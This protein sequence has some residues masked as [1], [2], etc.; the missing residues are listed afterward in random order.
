MPR[1]GAP[2]LSVAIF[3]DFVHCLGSFKRLTRQFGVIYLEEG[4]FFEC[5]P[6]RNIY[7]EEGSNRT[8]VS[9]PVIPVGTLF[10]ILADKNLVSNLPVG[11]MSTKPVL[12]KP[13]IN[14]LMVAGWHLSYR[15]NNRSQFLK[16]EKDFFP[17]T[18]K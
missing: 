10:S 4:S 18:R 7:L 2:H 15:S 17:E 6:V 16:T 1:A 12:T 8:S 14:R 5:S 11:Q 3:L 13:V 9:A